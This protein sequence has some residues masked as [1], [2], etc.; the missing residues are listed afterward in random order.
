MSQ[1]PKRQINLPGFGPLHIAAFIPVVLFALAIVG[2][3]SFAVVD[4]ILH[5]PTPEE[6]AE[7]ASK[8]AAEKEREEA[9]G[10]AKEQ[11]KRKEMGY[12]DDPESK[13]TAKAAIQSAGYSCPGVQGVRAMGDKGRGP[14]LRVQCTNNVFFSLTILPGNRGYT[15]TID[16]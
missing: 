6:R 9:A 7:R 12:L 2:V 4:T 14:V 11:K 16:E 8:R 5:P 15:V 1:S 3:V 13:K 10:V